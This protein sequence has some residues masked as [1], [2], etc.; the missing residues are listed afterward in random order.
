MKHY[1][2]PTSRTGRTVSRL[3]RAFSSPQAAK[4]ALRDW[5]KEANAT[6]KKKGQ[7][8]LRVSDFKIISVAPHPFAPGKR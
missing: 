6:R 2:R 1:I 4:D 7:D 8:P 5:L 3:N